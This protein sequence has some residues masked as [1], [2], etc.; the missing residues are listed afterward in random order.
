M[1]VA[2]YQSSIR[3][4]VIAN[5][6]TFAHTIVFIGASVVHARRFHETSH[7]LRYAIAPCTWLFCSEVLLLEAIAFLT[8]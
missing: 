3:G 1:S 5:A 7:S 6:E 2:V 8:A 4:I